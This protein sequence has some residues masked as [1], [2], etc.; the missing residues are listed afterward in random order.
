M[1]RP[2]AL[3]TAS[4]VWHVER[5]NRNADAIAERAGKMF[6]KFSGFLGDMQ[7]LGARLDMAHSSYSDA[8]NKLGRGQGNVIWQL[9]QLK[10]MGAKTTKSLPAGLS[11]DDGGLPE[12]A[13]GLHGPADAPEVEIRAAE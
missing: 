13:N 8:M 12:L 1:P 10:D 5:R 7:K 11:W 3:R 9:Q 4:N 2:I 6:D